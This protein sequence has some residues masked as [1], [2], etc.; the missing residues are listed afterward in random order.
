LQGGISRTDGEEVA[1]VWEDRT[2][3]LSEAE[4]AYRLEFAPPEGEFVRGVETGA[5]Q[6]VYPQA[7]I[8]AD[9]DGLPEEIEV[10]VRQISQAVGPGLPATRRFV[11]A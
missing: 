9:F 4:E 8:E 11:L 2:Q 6:F 5:S 1:H 10:T 3:V 7:A